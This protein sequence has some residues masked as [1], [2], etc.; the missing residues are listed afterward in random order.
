MIERRR[1]IRLNCRFSLHSPEAF[2]FDRN[3][4]TQTAASIESNKVIC[5]YFFL[6][7]WLLHMIY[8]HF[9]FLKWFNIAQHRECNEHLFQRNGNI[10]WERRFASHFGRRDI[11]S[12]DA[13]D[14]ESIN[15]DRSNEK[16][17]WKFVTSS[18]IH[19][20]SVTSGALVSQFS[21]D[22]F[23]FFCRI[24]SNFFLRL[25]LSDRFFLFHFLLSFS[26]TIP[27]HRNVFH[28]LLHS[29]FPNAN[30]ILIEVVLP[31]LCTART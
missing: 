27:I 25:F 28:S 10:K 14:F 19:T 15:L 20:F 11:E 29:Y 30:M 16:Y 31:S 7:I 17:I 1:N 26:W 2:R 23:F 22:S 12:Q 21:S 18:M 8:L 3:D 5:F 4:P 9:F 24:F 6:F 13:N